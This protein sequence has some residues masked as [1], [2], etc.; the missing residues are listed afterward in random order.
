MY[1]ITASVTN[2]LLSHQIKQNFYQGTDIET[3]HC[4][5]ED[6]TKLLS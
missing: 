5:Y 4:D 1:K 2:E 3:F 6:L